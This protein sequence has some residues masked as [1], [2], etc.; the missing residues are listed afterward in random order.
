MIGDVGQGLWEE[1]DYVAEADGGGR[2]TNFGWDCREGAHDFELEGCAGSVFTDLIW[3]YSHDAG[4]CS[5]TGGY[6]VR[7]RALPD[8]YGRYLYADF[9][10][11]RSAL[12]R[13]RGRA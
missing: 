10:V 7:D 9:C 12:D 4:N 11:G 3:E 13:P 8:L 2:A 1:I 6:V 5:I